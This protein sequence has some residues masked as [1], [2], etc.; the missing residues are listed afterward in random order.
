MPTLGV[1]YHKPSH[2]YVF[3]S[4]QGE[5]RLKGGG[6]GTQNIGSSSIQLGATWYMKV[7]KVK[8]DKGKGKG[9]E[10]EKEIKESIVEAEEIARM[11]QPEPAN[12]EAGS[13]WVDQQD[14]QWNIL[15][16]GTE[17]EEGEGVTT[18]EILEQRRDERRAAAAAQSPASVEQTDAGAS[19]SL[20]PPRHRSH[21]YSS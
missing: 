1:D 16:V 9:E 15:T 6:F 19:S 21:H 17:G 18:I 11:T 4:N 13:S 3:I 2:P 5:L 20:A 8:K 7:E 14:L 10:K 12:A